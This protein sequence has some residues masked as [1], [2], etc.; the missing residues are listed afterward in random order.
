MLPLV[1][2]VATLTAKFAPGTDAAAVQTLLP[3]M[4]LALAPTPSHFY[5]AA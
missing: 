3:Y 2:A 4:Y 1:L 5:C